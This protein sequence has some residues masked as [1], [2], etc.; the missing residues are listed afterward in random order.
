[1]IWINERVGK[2]KTPFSQDPDK[3]R[4][5]S[6]G[7]QAGLSESIFSQ[8]NKKQGLDILYKMA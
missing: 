8:F 4:M 1:M 3:N 2:P 7:I 6:W 5:V